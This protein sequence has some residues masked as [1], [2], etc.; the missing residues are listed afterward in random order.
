MP[1]QKL[2]SPVVRLAQRQQRYGAG[3]V[4]DIL[5]GNSTPRVTQARPH[6]PDGLRHR[7][8]ARRRRLARRR[9]GLLTSGVLTVGDDGY[10]T[11][12]VTDESWTVLRGERQVALRREAPRSATT[13]TRKARGLAGTKGEV[14]GFDA[15]GEGLSSGCAG[16]RAATAKEALSPGVRRLPRRD[17]A[18]GGRHAADLARSRWHLGHRRQQAEKWGPAGAGRPSPAEQ[19]SGRTRTSLWPAPQVTERPARGSRR[20]RRRRRRPRST[21]RRTTPNE[22]TTNASSSLSSPGY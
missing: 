5:L 13:R 6:R 7:R 12:Q 14:L 4:I 2:L 8:R 10:G 11:L 15:G 1:A 19:G 3:H 21:S 17:A 9:P 22:S 18:S 20:Q 16:L